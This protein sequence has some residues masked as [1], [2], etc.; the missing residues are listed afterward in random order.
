MPPQKASSTLRVL[1]P[2]IRITAMAAGRAPLASA[3]M[4]S[5]DAEAVSLFVSIR[6]PISLSI[7]LS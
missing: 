3:T 4:V 7:A 2:E 1:G 6:S 5:H